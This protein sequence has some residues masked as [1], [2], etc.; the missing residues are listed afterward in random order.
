MYFC[1]VRNVEK[2]AVARIV[3]VW[4]AKSER[5]KSPPGRLEIQK[6]KCQCIEIGQ[7]AGSSAGMAMRQRPRCGGGPPGRA[8]VGTSIRPHYLNVTLSP[9]VESKHRTRIGNMFLITSSSPPTGDQAKKTVRCQMPN[10]ATPAQPWVLVQ[11][12]GY[13]DEW[14]YVK[15]S[16][17]SFEA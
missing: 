10:A 13:G 6:F 14:A 16:H 17:D 5:Y 7:F 1:L 11:P 12:A 15:E 8:G 3:G 9:M 4:N 2:D